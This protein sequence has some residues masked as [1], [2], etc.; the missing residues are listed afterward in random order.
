MCR[1]SLLSARRPCLVSLYR[2]SLPTPSVG[3][4]RLKR[5]KAPEVEKRKAPPLSHHSH[6]ERLR[7]EIGL[8]NKQGKKITRVFPVFFSPVNSENTQSPVAQS[9]EGKAKAE[10]EEG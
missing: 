3:P 9:G 2:P 5:F 7:C 1:P 8:E 6:H 10:R 4:T